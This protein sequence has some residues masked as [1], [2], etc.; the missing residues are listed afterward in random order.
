M[1][2]FSP[3]LYPL[4]RGGL[5]RGDALQIIVLTCELNR[6]REVNMRMIKCH[7]ACVRHTVRV[8]KVFLEVGKKIHC[9]SLY[10]ISL[11]FQRFMNV[12]IGKVGHVRN[13]TLALL[14]LLKL[15]T[16]LSVLPFQQPPTQ[17]HTVNTHTDKPRPW[18]STLAR[19]KGHWFYIQLCRWKELGLHHVPGYD[20]TSVT[21]IEANI[22][23]GYVFCSR[24]R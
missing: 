22:V 7:S 6:A 13:S 19:T 8:C 4:L 21:H 1:G 2:E 16:V 11:L 24:D 14:R 5:R 3:C 12:S 20:G 9:K 23:G 10:W 15:L 18:P 17:T